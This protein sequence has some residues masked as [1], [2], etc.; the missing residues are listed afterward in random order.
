MIKRILLIHTLIAGLLINVFPRE[1]FWIPLLLEKYNE[2]EMQQ[3]GMKISAEDIYSVNNSSLKDAIVRFG[4]GCTAEIISGQGLLL[5]NHHCGYRQ[6][7]AHSTVEH[8]YLT[9]G[10]WAKNRKQELPN[11]GLKATRLV[12][13]KD[14]T[15]DVLK[16]IEQNITEEKREELI[17]ERISKITKKAVEGTHYEAKIEPFYYGNQYFMFIT[18]TFKDIRLV[19]APP[20]SIGKFGKDLDNWMW[21]RH[22]GD[23]SIFR[24]YVNENN[25]PAAYSD[26]NVPYKP[27]KHMKISLDGYKKGDFTFVFGYPGRTQEYLTSHAIDMIV[28]KENPE[29]IDLRDQRLK[30]M[31]KYMKKSDKIRIQ[32]SAKY[33]GVANY[34]KKFQGENRGI[35]RMNAIEIKENQQKKFAQW[36][37]SNPERQKRYGH[38]LPEFKETYKK[39]TPYNLAFDYLIEA[40]LAVEIIRFSRNFN[41]L[42]SA[43]RAEENSQSKIKE[44][45]ASILKSAESFFSDYHKPIDKGVLAEL[46]DDYYKEVDS[47]FHPNNFKEIKKK[48][49]ENF[50]IYADSIFKH[51][52]MDE[53]ETVKSFLKDFKKEDHEKIQ[54]DPIYRLASHIYSVY[55]LKIMDKREEYQTH[56]DSLYRVYLEGQMKMKQ[57]EYFYPDANSTLRVAYGKVKGYE[58]RNAVDYNY[59]TTLK[60]VFEKESTGKPD[61]KVPEK[62]SEVYQAKDYGRYADQDGSMHVCFIASNHT[63]GGNSGSP[64]LDDRGNL[65]GVNFDRNWEGTMSDLMYDPEQC[66]NIS[67]DIRYCL[68]II[69]KYADAN[70]L[71]KEMTIVNN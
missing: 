63:S 6:I 25:E 64:V 21:P 16:N 14:V 67:L 24:I 66:R 46:Y 70:H 61:Y 4:G 52:F 42:I 53:L 50:E 31:D 56:L 37:A 10:F 18:E 7:Q 26:D 45:K 28:N 44:A 36:A 11:E 49:N 9:N 68:F 23:F 22:T 2:A 8:D 57:D 19:G 39:L 43:A 15:E 34:Y 3:M 35:K 40:G 58:P 51:S 47:K 33:A 55:Y 12:R 60:G 17:K 59:Y 29:K 48:H 65:I 27:K 20:S 54:E 13:M 32:Y 69:D 62:L 41:D 30:I 1:G 5:T 71:I 38:L